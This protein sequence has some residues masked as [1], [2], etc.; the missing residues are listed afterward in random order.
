MRKMKN[1]LLW[2]DHEKALIFK[3]NKDL[4]V[5]AEDKIVPKHGHAHHNHNPKDIKDKGF[6]GFYQRVAADIND[7]EELVL[8][9]PGVAK[10]EF[11]HYC[12]NHLPRLAKNIVAIEVAAS[13]PNP[14]ELI[15]QASKYYSA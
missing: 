14:N 10:N 5:V 4:E 12:E 9:G 3:M 11:H 6:I 13:H 8:M 2:I 15:P 7:A 1:Y